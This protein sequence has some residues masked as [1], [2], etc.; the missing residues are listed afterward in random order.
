MFPPPV[1]IA[2]VNAVVYHRIK[3]PSNQTLATLGLT[4]GHLIAVISDGANTYY[5]TMKPGA[6][7][8]GGATTLAALETA[9]L[10]EEL[11]AAP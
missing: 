11:A 1:S 5:T 7:L 9:G 8:Q 4:P 3:A 6:Q 2:D 10:V